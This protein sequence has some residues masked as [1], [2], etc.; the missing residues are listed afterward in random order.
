[1]QATTADERAQRAA[2]AVVTGSAGAH[3]L[4]AV[5][6]YLRRHGLAVT[7]SAEAD[8]AKVLCWRSA[9]ESVEAV[10]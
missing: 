6:T 10:A 8:A 4:A 2:V 1:M 5:H 7:G 9:I 3:D